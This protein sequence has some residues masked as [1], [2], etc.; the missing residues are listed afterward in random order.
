MTGKGKSCDRSKPC[1]S[2]ERKITL[3][4]RVKISYSYLYVGELDPE[5]KFFCEDPH[6]R[7]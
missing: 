5:A 3:L 1:E 7:S 2:N 6:Y 4:I